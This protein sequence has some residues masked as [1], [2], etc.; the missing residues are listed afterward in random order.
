[1]FGINNVII[2]LKTMEHI[3]LY[4]II[5]EEHYYLVSTR[6]IN[7]MCKIDVSMFTIQFALLLMLTFCIGFLEEV[8]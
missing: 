3:E 7:F 8:T 5:Y 6:I 2:A 4:Y 1:M